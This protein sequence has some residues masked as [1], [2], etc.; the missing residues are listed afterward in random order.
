MRLPF[1]N[2]DVN[3]LDIRKLYDLSQNAP[4][5]S[6]DHDDDGINVMGG[7]GIDP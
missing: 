7:S 2:P 4:L 6:M 3:K 5:P 1:N